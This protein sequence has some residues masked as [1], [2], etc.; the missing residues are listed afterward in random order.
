M[1]EAAG[2]GVKDELSMYKNNNTED[3]CGTHA[4]RSTKAQCNMA[5]IST[6]NP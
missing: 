1:V 5:P 3:D 2:Q 6:S 4:Q